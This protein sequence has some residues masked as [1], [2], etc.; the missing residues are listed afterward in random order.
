MNAFTAA[1]IVSAFFANKSIYQNFWD[2]I[3]A[4]SISLTDG[5]SLIAVAMTIRAIWK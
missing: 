3:D 2:A 5:N 1:S 4:T